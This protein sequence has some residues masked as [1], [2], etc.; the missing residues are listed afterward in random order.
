MGSEVTERPPPS[1]AED[2]DEGVHSSTPT[3]TPSCSSDLPT[4]PSHSSF[5][6]HALEVTPDSHINLDDPFQVG[7]L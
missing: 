4:T 7:Y 5:D 1:V 3:P 6:G 2:L